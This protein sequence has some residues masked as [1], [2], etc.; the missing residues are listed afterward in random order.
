MSFKIDYNIA[1]KIETRYFERLDTIRKEAKTSKIVIHDD[2]YDTDGIKIT[3]RTDRI[4][5]PLGNSM[6]DYYHEVVIDV[7][8]CVFTVRN[9][10]HISAW[11]RFVIYD[12]RNVVVFDVS[13]YDESDVASAGRNSISAHKTVSLS[14]T[15]LT[16]AVTNECREI[17]VGR[18]EKVNIL[19]VRD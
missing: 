8:G 16:I 1:K 13:T 10:H 2:V 7:L 17:G 11:A 19:M 12:A 3:L 18:G 4:L 9:P 5:F 6:D 15:S 14:G